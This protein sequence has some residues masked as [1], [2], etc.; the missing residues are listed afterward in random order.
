MRNNQLQTRKTSYVYESL[1]SFIQ[2]I[3]IVLIIILLFSCSKRSDGY[4]SHND[5]YHAFRNVSAPIGQLHRIYDQISD[6]L[7]YAD[8]FFEVLDNEEAIRD[9]R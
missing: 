1:K 5:A 7:I 6:A 3:G 9:W 4:W 8:G 2:Q